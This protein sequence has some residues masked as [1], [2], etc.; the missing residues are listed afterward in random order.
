MLKAIILFLN[1]FFFS[2]IGL[3]QEKERFMDFSFITSQHSIIENKEKQ[4]LYNIET[5]YTLLYFYNPECEN[6][7]KIKKKLI[8]NKSLN[9]LIKENKITLLAVVPDV[10]KEYWLDNLGC[11]PN[12]WINAWNKNDEK[13][14]STYLHTVP[15]FFILDREKNIIQRPNEREV[16][17]WIK[18]IGK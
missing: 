10:E 15:T 5:D 2:L 17:K 13:I 1:L 6:C 9:K 3:A 16:L 4:S 18:T 7:D 12:N 11:V 14:I 8:K